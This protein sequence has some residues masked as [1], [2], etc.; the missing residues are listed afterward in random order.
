MTFTMTVDMDNAAFKDGD[1]G[2]DD[3]SELL[4]CLNRVREDVNRGASTRG[5]IR[6]SNGNHVGSWE[7][8]A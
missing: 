8:R 1:D 2:A 3:I 4:A 6:D 7:I 5:T